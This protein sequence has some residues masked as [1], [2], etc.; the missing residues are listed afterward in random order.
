[1]KKESNLRLKDLRSKVNFLLN[2]KIII[3]L[4]S[5]SNQIYSILLRMMLMMLS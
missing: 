5:S 3:V 4:I 2:Y 1:M